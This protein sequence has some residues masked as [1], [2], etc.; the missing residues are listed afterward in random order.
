[1]PTPEEPVQD[2]LAENERLRLSL[3][4][5]EETLDAIRSGDVDALVVAGPQG[6]QVYALAGSDRAYRILFET[7]NEGAAILAS[8]GAV[9]F[10]NTKLAAMLNIP[11][12]TII[13]SSILR[14][15]SATDVPSVGGLLDKG[16]K[17]PQKME[18]ALN[19]ENGDV[20]PCLMSTSPFSDEETSAICAVLTDLTQRKQAE[21][22]LIRSNQDLQQFSYVTSHDL[23]EPL[24]NVA[25]C[26]QMLEK[27]YKNKLDAD[28]DKLIN[29][30]VESSVRMKSLILDLLAYSRVATK[31]KLPER[32]DCE[33]VLDQT[34]TNLRSAIS[35]SGAVI[36]RDPLP[37]IRADDTQMLQVFQNLLQNAIKF[38]RD[39][40]PKV[41][42]S[43]VKNK[44]EWQF[45]VR[46]N[47][48]GIESEHLDRIFVIFQ[49]LHK[50]SQYD[51]TGMGLAIVKKV[52]E[53]HGGR[54]WV[55]SE[56]G[57]GSTFYFTMPAKEI[58]T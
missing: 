22:E 20:V 52:V 6:D 27:K 3:R 55:K 24:R 36:T 45:S 51:G 7:M 46:D 33:Q 21:E 57:V 38:R 50:R 1:M 44:K 31:G 13:G 41:H 10:S 2:L 12:E 54:V 30:A 23:Q 53:R 39:E 25:S 8:D 4:E 16:L 56:P 35:E 28:A 43:A 14:F 49:R 37:M 42:V 26:L 11:M 5:A 32:I 29:Y 18:I 40:P 9:L 17:E 19:S 15:V 48:I 34:V 47:G 58:R